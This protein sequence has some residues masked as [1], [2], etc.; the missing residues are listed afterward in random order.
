MFGAILSQID[1]SRCS[2]GRCSITFDDK[3]TNYYLYKPSDDTDTISFEITKEANP[4]RDVVAII[5]VFSEVRIH[6]QGWG[7]KEDSVINLMRVPG[8]SSSIFLRPN[9]VFQIGDV[10]LQV[11]PKK[12][13]PEIQVTSSGKVEAVA[14]KKDNNSSLGLK[15]GEVIEA[16]LPE[17]PSTPR[18]QSPEAGSAHEFDTTIMETPAASRHYNPD[19]SDSSLMFA[20]LEHG[21]KDDGERSKAALP[22]TRGVSELEHKAPLEAYQTTAKY[23]DDKTRVSNTDGRSL[24]LPKDIVST[25]EEI[26][27]LDISV[28]TNSNN[29]DS[30]LPSPQ[31]ELLQIEQNVLHI[32]SGF[33][34]NAEELVKSPVEMGN[35]QSPI[36][37][38]MK[39]GPRKRKRPTRE[40]QGSVESLNHVATSPT[41]QGNP[42]E[43][44]P[45]KYGT[46]ATKQNTKKS[47]VHSVR[48][49]S[50][51]PPSASARGTR[52]VQ[53]H[54]H[55]PLSSTMTEEPRRVFFSSS[56]SIDRT[57][58]RLTFLE[59]NGVTKVNSVE[60]CDILCV[61]KGELKKTGS[62]VLAVISGKEVITDDWISTSISKGELLDPRSFLAHDPTKEAEWKIDLS[63]AIE[64]GRRGIKPF[65]NISCF[66]TSAAKKDLG[67]GFT[68]L[69]IIAIHAGAKSVQASIP[70]KPNQL[71]DK[72]KTIIIAAQDDGELSALEEAGWR[73][74]NK[75]IITL[76]VLRGT[77][78]VE[79]N[80]FLIHRQIESNPASS[81]KRLKRSSVK[82]R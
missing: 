39:R 74:F 65:L 82:S 23:D 43:N 10:T 5:K 63:E 20:S 25:S 45:L 12:G 6:T 69:K 11:L 70:R 57:S 37:A 40:S 52:S 61:G 80:E 76:S 81:N 78:D 22:S 42:I 50:E 75:D 53:I 28:T 17:K 9:D 7:P 24:E 64:R 34:S 71:G 14:D 56:T 8:K 68:D 47:P 32:A 30:A 77:V 36:P 29:G 55:S 73:C 15:P 49:L 72:S 2:L 66:F 33:N 3:P 18:K 51:P 41:P 21:M 27:I 13:N 4:T 38:R 62:L 67:K 59:R 46:E 16:P 19:L 44:Q 58:K 31:A 60:E 79:S 1:P 48:D 54:E 26:V 35:A